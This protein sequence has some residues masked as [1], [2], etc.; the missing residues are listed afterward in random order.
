MQRND[1]QEAIFLASPELRNEILKYL[2]G[3]LKHKD[4]DRLY[5]SVLKYLTRMST[6][7]TPFGL[8]AGCSTGI[9]ADIMNFKVLGSPQ[10]TMHTRLDM[11]YLC[12]LAYDISMRENVKSRLRY[13][14]NTSCYVIGNQLRYIEIHY[15]NGFR[16]HRIVSV[17][18]SDYLRQLLSAIHGGST[19]ED[20]VQLLINEDIS[21][22]EAFGFIIELIDNQIVVGE[23]DPSITGPDLLSQLIISLRKIGNLEP[24][25]E[26]LQQ[27]ASCLDK[28]D[29]TPIGTHFQLYNELQDTITNLGVIYNKQYLI[30]TDMFKPC[31]QADIAEEIVESVLEGMSFLNKLSQDSLL[32]TK[33]GRLITSFQER[34]EEQE[35]SLLHLLDPD[36]G[37]DFQQ[38]G[39]DGDVAPLIDGIPF[40]S[41][42]RPLE[43][44]IWGSVQSTIHRKIIDALEQ[45]HHEVVLTDSDFP[46][47]EA[48]W[49]DLPPTFSVICKIFSYESKGAKKI[50]FDSFGGT[51]AGNLLGRFCHINYHIHNLVQTI[52]ESEDN[53][54]PPNALYA[55]IVHLP[56]ARTGNILARPALRKYEIPYLTKSGVDREFQIPLSDLMVSLK[57]GKFVLRSKKMNMEIIPR[58]TTSHAYSH[59]SMPIY[60]FLCSAQHQGKSSFGFYLS[61]LLGDLP[62]IPRI[63]YKDNIFSL[64]RWKILISD[65]QELWKIS[66]KLSKM[67]AIEKWKEV[68][69]IPR[70]VVLPDGD[71]EL[72][73][74]TTST[75]SLQ[76]LYSTIKRRRF[77]ILQEFPFDTE[78]PVIKNDEG[79]FANEFIFSFVS[80]KVNRDGG[81]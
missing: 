3:T 11:N 79:A 69:G 48:K 30:Q 46:R 52:I 20:M 71:N 33:R 81:S 37:I 19:I 15:I 35:V 50:Y 76:M 78:H 51:S 12:A 44:P 8:F 67:T 53:L 5:S 28:I 75:L 54:L 41:E 16:K 77:F 34:Y 55:E 61:N 65:F 68:K 63:S 24:L 64:A 72:F 32:A 43:N 58:L 25:V 31:Q 59:Q 7:C 47:L 2:E 80:N 9:L 57:G 74:D 6:R 70:F 27:L 62:Y 73:I 22:D 1:I 10:Y 4:I 40:G 66:E 26:Q 18:H 39:F 42:D 49:G 23:I 60:H 45:H 29:S 17:N 56:E 13:Y 21:R 14:P 38:I 36:I